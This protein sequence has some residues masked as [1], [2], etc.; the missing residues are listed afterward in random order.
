MNATRI[1]LFVF[2]AISL[3]IAVLAAY[4]QR[5]T[6]P[7]PRVMVSLVDPADYPDSPHE[8]PSGPPITIECWGDEADQRRTRAFARS[9]RN[10]ARLRAAIDTADLEAKLA[11]FRYVSW[12]VQ[13]ATPRELAEAKT[14]SDEADANLER[15]RGE[16]S[17][18]MDEQL[19]NI[20]SSRTSPHPL[21][22][23]TIRAANGMRYGWMVTTGVP[24]PD[25]P[26]FLNV[27][28]VFPYDLGFQDTTRVEAAQ[29]EVS[30]QREQ[31]A[32]RS[33]DPEAFVRAELA[34]EA[35]TGVFLEAWEATRS[36]NA[37][38]DAIR[39]DALEACAR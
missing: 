36:R 17:A 30:E 34:L 27:E 28:E 9:R 10:D 37:L 13:D 35:A 22:A 4:G 20:V 33:L 15:L 11:G 2:V 3:F 12:L 7:A 26:A 32:A 21:T 14:A 29:A 38:H 31:A 39:Q 16:E 23:I 18:I 24:H 6:R 1:V 25:A 8:W 19:V 5:S